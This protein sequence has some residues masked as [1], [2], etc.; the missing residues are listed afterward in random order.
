MNLLSN[1]VVDALLSAVCQYTPEDD[2][3]LRIQARRK[4][5]LEEDFSLGNEYTENIPLSEQLSRIA[6]FLIEAIKE[7]STRIHVCITS[8][9]KHPSTL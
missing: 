6:T 1:K 7:K 8:Y 3:F 5:V 4:A 2:P 9:S